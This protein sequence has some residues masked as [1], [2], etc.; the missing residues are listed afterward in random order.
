MMKKFAFM[1][2]LM[3]SAGIPYLLSTGGEWVASAK[4]YMNS[5]PAAAQQ[6]ATPAGANAAAPAPA[7]FASFDA[8][9]PQLPSSVTKVP[10]LEGYGPYNLAEVINFGVTPEWVTSR[11][12]RV[13]VGLAEL[14]MQGYRVTLVTGTAQDDLAGSLTYYFDEGRE[15]KLIHFLGTTGDPR[16][17]IALVMSQYKFRPQQTGDPGL[18]LYQY[19]WLG[20]PLSELQV[21]MTSVI[22]AS[23]PFNRYQVELALRR[24]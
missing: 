6:Q 18:Q 4:N 16:K 5:P 11:W 21:R 15:L 14:N 17:L 20:K 10:P 8:S 19:R 23:Q 9:L 24:P 12:P 22:L 13:T 7:Q 2:V 1:S 3:S